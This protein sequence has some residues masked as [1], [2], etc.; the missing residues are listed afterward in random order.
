MGRRRKGEAVSGWI[1]LD[2]P[3]D[4]TSTQ[5]VGRVRR[6]F[7]AQK[8]GHA[9]TLDPLA[10]GVL[11]L[12]LG[13]ATKTV[14]YMVEADKGY[15]FTIA[16]GASTTTLDREGEI[17]ARSDVRPTPDQ[18]KAVLHEFEGEVMQVPPIYS[19]IKVDGERAY[20]LARAGEAVELKARPV[21][22]H[23]LAVGEAPDADHI[24]LIMDCGKGAYVRSVVR[25]LA[26]RLGAE[27]HVS[28][29]RRTRVGAFTEARAIG[30]DLLE[31]LGHKARQSEA[32]LPVE[33][34]LDDIPALA[35]TDE[36]AFRLK[37]G[38]SIVLVPRQVE[39]LRAGLAPGART[40]SAMC[41]GVMVALCEMRAGK[42]EPSRVF[43]L[44]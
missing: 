34:A 37:Q 25:D 2:K 9:G 27:A 12:A 10:T 33:T 29:L 4:L 17:T 16:W 6:I 7:N 23:G 36:D 1:C 43:H 35:V 19:A 8:A 24:E 26:L 39:T 31:E 3:Y 20:D 15:R 32:L 11:P 42:L 41:R 40:V 13:E 28:A 44:E 21:M 18:V 22:I 30:L 14:A 38:R 5:A